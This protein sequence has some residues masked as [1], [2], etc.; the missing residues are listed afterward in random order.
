M[1]TLSVEEAR[2][3]FSLLVEQAS[4]THERFQITRNGSR[5][6]VLMGTD[7]YDAM[8]ETLA[9]VAD[10]DLAQDIGKGLRDLAQGAAST[11][12]QVRSKMR[13]GPPRE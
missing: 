10:A 13:L 6:A 8:I 9:V 3:H 1:R 2:D 7:D 5:A 12:D 11:A 4:T